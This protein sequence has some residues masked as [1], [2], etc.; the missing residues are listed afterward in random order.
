M[1][2][3]VTRVGAIAAAN[4]LADVTTQERNGT[5]MLRALASGTGEVR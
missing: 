5:A 2:T 4:G 3:G 1:P